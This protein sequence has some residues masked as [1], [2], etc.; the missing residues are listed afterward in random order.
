MIFSMRRAPVTMAGMLLATTC[1]L[2][3]AHAQTQNGYFNLTVSQTGVGRI[4]SD[5]GGIRCDNICT[6]SFSA[7]SGNSPTCEVKMH[8][9]KTV[10][11]SFKYIQLPCNPGSPTG[12]PAT[13]K[14]NAP[15]TRADGTALTGLTGYKINR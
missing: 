15:V 14:W 9:A 10:T 3:V 5:I 8:S 7:G 11:A 1:S 4:T 13:I 12:A 2:S 6:V